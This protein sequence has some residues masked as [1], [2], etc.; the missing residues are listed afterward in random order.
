MPAVRTPRGFTRLDVLLSIALISAIAGVSL[1]LYQ[2]FQVRNDLHVAAT[3]VAQS[4]RRAQVLSQASDGDTTWGVK[5]QSGS[6][7]VF[8]GA[9]YATRDTAEDE[10]FDVPT[11]IVPTGLNEVVFTKFTGDPSATGT[12]TLTSSTSEVVSI[13]IN[14]RGTVT[15]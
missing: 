3:T 6:T 10:I 7:V 8:R 12:V 9:T 14:S 13:A 11:S 15:Y 1:P 4:F 2:S 5:V